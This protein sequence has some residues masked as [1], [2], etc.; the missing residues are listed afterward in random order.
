MSMLESI[1]VA[2]FMMLTVFAVLFGLCLCVKGFSLLCARL[3][4]GGR[5]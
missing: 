2:I 1:S 3:E 4:R 5:K